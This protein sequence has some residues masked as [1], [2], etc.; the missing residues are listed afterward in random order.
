MNYLHITQ[1]LNHYRLNDLPL[2][3]F[4]SKLRLH[5]YPS[6]ENTCKKCG[7]I[8]ISFTWMRIKSI[9]FSDSKLIKTFVGVIK[10]WSNKL[11]IE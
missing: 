1:V 6:Y 11:K 3:K 7:A 8:N 10:N 2:I 5:Q 4:S 9:F